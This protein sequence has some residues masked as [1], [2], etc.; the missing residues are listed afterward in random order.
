MHEFWSGTG[1]NTFFVDAAQR[2]GFDGSTI[3]RVNFRPVRTLEVT[4]P[5]S[6]YTVCCAT[7]RVTIRS[8]FTPKRLPMRHYS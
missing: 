5:L 8:V 7:Q 4:D 6:C 2:E 3:A 1:W